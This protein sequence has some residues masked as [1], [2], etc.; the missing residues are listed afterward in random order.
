VFRVTLPSVIL[1]TTGLIGLYATIR[2]I[3]TYP[4]LTAMLVLPAVG[5]GLAVAA[6][7]VV[8]L[9]KWSII[10]RYRPRVE[11]YWGTWV[12]ATELI[13][14][15]F[16]TVAAPMVA[17]F[18]GTPLLPVMLRLFGVRVGRR[19]Y[20]TTGGGTEFDLID[21][22]DDVVIAEGAITQT[23]LFEDRVMKMSRVEVGSGA[24][25]GSGAVV[26]YDAAVGPGAFLDALS[27]VMKGETLPAR[28]R[29]RGIPARPL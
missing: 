27:L 29:W 26:L 18:A 13:T 11:P 14:G 28:S 9:L 3:G 8:V 22:G 6:T 7:L 2:V 25:V 16:E 10:G 17:L 20:L 23:H 12:R 19:V 5:F 24:T 15:L 4:P 21:I 1:G